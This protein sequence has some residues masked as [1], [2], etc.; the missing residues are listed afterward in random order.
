MKKIKDLDKKT[1]KSLKSGDNVLYTGIMFTARDQAH[2]RLVVDI[3]NNRVP[4]NLKNKIIYYCGPNPSKKKNKVGSAGPTT[5]SRMD[6]FTPMLLKHGVLALV[7]KGKRS[8]EVLH[9]LQKNKAVY[10]ITIAGAGAYLS[11]K[12][13]TAFPVAYKDLGAE[14]IYEFYVKDFPL[15][16]ACDTRGRT[17][18]K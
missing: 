11:E 1:A 12:I 7:G 8:K 6:E 4:I 15:I 3:K 17:I 10:F 9:A 14:S 5:S 18:F 16:V 13:K 2:K